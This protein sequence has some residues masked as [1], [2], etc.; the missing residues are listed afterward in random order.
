[1]RDIMVQR[2][3]AEPVRLQ[4]YLSECGVLSR[5]A[6]EEAILNGTVTVNG[7]PAVLGQKVTAGQDEVVYGGKKIR[8]LIGEKIYIRL[9]KPV[10]Y[11]TTLSDDKGRPCVASLV[12]NVGARVYPC[13]RL[14]MDSEGLLIL[15]NDGELANKLTHPRH[16]IPKIYHV[17][18]DA[19]ITLEQLEKLNLPMEIDGYTILPVYTELLSRRDGHSNVRM[20]LYE[21]RNRQI[22]K[23]CEQVGL[24]VRRLKRV[25][26]G[27]ITLGRLK[28]G[29]WD[30]LT[31][32]QVNYL[33][34]R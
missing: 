29:Q 23:M 25:A 22:R 6:A 31:K 11:V 1:M 19:E 32:E 14:D 34:T 28:P 4:K 20:T 7:Q 30:Y 2:K 8:P 10:G 17:K 33:Q 9:N 16:T 21:G 12:E 13:G 26:V 15:T 24:G 27:P 5:R 3:K 18:L